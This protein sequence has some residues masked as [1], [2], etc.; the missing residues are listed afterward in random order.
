MMVSEQ[1]LNC[2]ISQE[3]GALSGLHQQLVQVAVMEILESVAKL[4]L[5]ELPIL[6]SQE[7]QKAQKR[8]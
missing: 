3:Q 1:Y 6:L 7:D 4:F 8:Q 5:F 2:V